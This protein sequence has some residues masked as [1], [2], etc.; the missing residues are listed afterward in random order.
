MDPPG[1]KELL[2]PAEAAEYLK[3]HRNTLLRWRQSG[4]GPPAIQMGRQWRYR[5]AALDQWLSE[6]ETGG[7]SMEA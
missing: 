3:V 4:T 1:S 2:T 7:E 5:R 6:G